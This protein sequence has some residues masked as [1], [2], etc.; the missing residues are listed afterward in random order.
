MS[1]VYAYCV[2]PGG[3]APPP[4]LTGLDAAAVR[5]HEVDG[6]TV[7]VSDEP[8]K[9]EPELDNIRRHHAVVM[10]ALGRNVVPLRFGAW[11]ATP[12]HLDARIRE[13]RQRLEGALSR[14][15]GRVEFGI[16]IQRTEGRA[17]PA[18][19]RDEAPPSSGREYLRAVS[20]RHG[21]RAAW[22][23][24]QERAVGCARGALREVVSDERIEYLSPPELVTLAHLVR[25]EDESAYR[26]R[27]E[28]IHLESGGEHLVHVTGPWPPYS[29]AWS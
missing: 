2:V 22:R 18:E 24:E 14:L 13:M 4:G 26:A 15:E 7:W 17:P 25:P 8:A 23:R 20:R 9:P 19:P 5:A 3:T 10:S 21:E 29:F 11:T 28:L 16:R 6:L 12:D 1:G 27:A